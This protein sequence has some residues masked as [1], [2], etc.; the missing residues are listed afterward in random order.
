VNERTFQAGHAHKLDD[1]ARLEWLPPSEVLDRLAVQPGSMVADIG[2]G[3]G[4]F[5]I[6]LARAAGPTGRV[7]A[8]DFQPAMLARIR[9]KLDA[10]DAPAN[11]E[12][13]EGSADRTSLP[14]ATCDLAF[15][16]NIWHEVDDPAKVIEEAGRILKPAGRLAILDWRSD[17]RSPP[18]PPDDHRLAAA[19]VAASLSRNGWRVDTNQNVGQY[20]YL[21]QARHI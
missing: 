21:I 10:A 13:V 15:F 11:I 19:D 7:F 12:L 5:A 20:S 8:V 9:A 2:A 17:R 16:A 4:Y 14:E 6:P 18:G 3:T 1:P